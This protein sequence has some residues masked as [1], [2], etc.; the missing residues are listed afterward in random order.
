MVLVGCKNWKQKGFFTSFQ[1]IGDALCCLSLTI[2]IIGSGQNLFWHVTQKLVTVRLD[3]DKKLIIHH[4]CWLWSLVEIFV[5]CRV[6]GQL[7][8]KANCQAEDSSKK[9]TNEFVFTSMRR[10]FVRFF[11]ESSARKKRFEIIWPLVGPYRQ[12]KLPF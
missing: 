6:K 2:A 3:T 4:F 8:S 12:Q 1:W 9:R 5:G 10:V 7:I 11:E